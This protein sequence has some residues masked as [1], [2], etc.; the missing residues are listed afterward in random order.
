[1]PRPAELPRVLTPN[2][3]AAYLRISRSALDRL[4]LPRIQLGARTVRYRRA[5]LE[6]F[7]QSREIKIA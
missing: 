6:A 3:A 2:E 7:E 4:H 5:D 1:M